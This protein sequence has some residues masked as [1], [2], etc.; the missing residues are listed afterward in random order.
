MT[1]AIALLDK[2]IS[3]CEDMALDLRDIGGRNADDKAEKYAAVARD[4]MDVKAEFK[5]LRLVYDKAARTIIPEDARA[6]LGVTDAM[7]TTAIQTFW[8]ET[9]ARDHEYLHARYGQ[10]MRSVL[11]AVLQKDR[12][13]V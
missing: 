13:N 9:Y 10:L 3:Y 11:E 4:L 8:A 1:N 6:A 2:H 12:S 7:V 5:R